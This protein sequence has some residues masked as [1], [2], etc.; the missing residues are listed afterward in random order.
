MTNLAIVIS[1]SDYIGDARPLPAC[2]NDGSA[3]FSII[4]ASGR[5][6]EILYINSDTNASPVKER[7][8]NFTKGYIGKNVEEVF[9]Y[10]TG[11]GE[12][13]GDELY[14]LLSD[15]Q[16]KKRKQTSLEN[17]ELDGLIRALSPNLFIK[18]V[19]ACHSGIS[20]IKSSDEFREYIKSSNQK[21]GKLYFMFSSQS[22][23]FSYQDDS[24][25]YF[26][27]SVLKAI[28]NHGSDT[29]R[30]KDVMSFVS[31]DFE[32]RTEQTP[33]FVT[34]AD[35][36]EI[37]CSITREL[38][39]KIASH[40]HDVDSLS[41]STMSPSEKSMLFL[42]RIREDA[43]RYCKK[44]EAILVVKNISELASSFQLPNHLKEIYSLEVTEEKI[45][46]MEASAIGNWIDGKGIGQGFFAKA[47][48]KNEIF[49]KRIQKDAFSRILSAGG[50]L[51]EEGY[52]Y[53]DAERSVVSGFAYT[54]DMP[55]NYISIKLIPALDNLT[56]E[57]CFIVPMVS[58]TKLRLFWSFAHY[59]YIDWDRTK[60]VGK[61]EWLTDEAPLKEI[62][63]TQFMFSEIT[64]Q[65]VT[66]IEEPLKAT[67]GMDLPEE[68]GDEKSG[69]DTKVVTNRESNGNKKENL[70]AKSTPTDA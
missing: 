12:F 41:S 68:V 18:I 17:T 44:D 19:D 54:T 49:K 29:I 27:E 64:R 31:D 25:S 32:G 23:Q 36:T 43:R 59:E 34:Q 30:Y 20:Y 14:Y 2:K 33:M 1:V 35:F 40:L 63:T 22:N 24:I 37:F 5:F 45:E 26:T 58:R 3:I 51:G 65:F 70:A 50:L 55:Y 62:S 53:V 11:H 52:T 60:R 6:D 13:S 47:T 28:H 69:Q 57:E 46:P 4:E 48:R 21:L 56:P 42:D 9:F 16:S 15:Y 10:F 66:F 8:A 7:L 61:L 38:R 67:W 39:E